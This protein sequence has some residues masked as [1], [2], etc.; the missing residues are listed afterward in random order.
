[1]ETCG[2]VGNRF[3]Y[4]DNVSRRC[5]AR[6]QDVRDEV[7]EKRINREGILIG[8]YSLEGRS[9]IRAKND[10]DGGKCTWRAKTLP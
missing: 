10:D 9:Y 6:R 8:Y 2:W 3:V 7:W 4:T 1:M 5:P